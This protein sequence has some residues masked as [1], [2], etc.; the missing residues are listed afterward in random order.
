MYESPLDHP[1]CS[2]VLAT[3]PCA[4]HRCPLG[5]CLPQSALCN[6]RNDCHDGSDEDEAKCRE[7]KQRCAPG[8]MKCRSSAKCVPKSKFCDHVPDCEDMTDE[9]TICS[10]FTYLQ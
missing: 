8:E 2:N 6:G 7:L 10:C 4:T 1:H 3:P 9:P 5:A